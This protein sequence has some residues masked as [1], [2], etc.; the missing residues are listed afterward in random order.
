MRATE[1]LKE[2]DVTTT[3]QFPLNELTEEHIA[4]MV[5]ILRR[6]CSPF[7]QNNLANMQ[8]GEFIYRGILG[9]GR[10]GSFLQGTVRTD[11]RP[12][13]SSNLWHNLMNKY[14]Q[15]VFG[16]PYRSAALFVS[17]SIDEVHHY[18]VPFVIFPKGQY[19]ICYSPVI[20]DVAVDLA[21]STFVKTRI[22]M[23]VRKVAAGIP[24]SV[25]AVTAEPLGLP[26]RDSVSFLEHMLQ[27]YMGLLSP[28]DTEKMSA[29]VEQV[30]FPYLDYQETLV[31]AYAN[32]SE[33]MIRC[34]EYYGIK[35]IGNRDF[36]TLL[37]QAL[38]S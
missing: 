19:K 3:G 20:E 24:S 7:L 16:W 22:P 12:L 5:E 26:I 10:E 25:Y 17:N 8:G 32:A 29:L 2:A 14:F 28:E 11:R 6:D 1:F 15:R 38:S 33:Q 27:F 23:P 36:L 31:S 30:L 18:G 21:G 4:P 13:D 9:G 34:S 37:A 35:A